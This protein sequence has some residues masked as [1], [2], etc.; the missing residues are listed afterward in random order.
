MPEPIK[1][2][3][4][5]NKKTGDEVDKPKKGDTTSKVIEKPFTLEDGTKLRE[6]IDII[7]YRLK[8]LTKIGDSVSNEIQKNG[9][10]GTFSYFQLGDPIEMESILEGD[11]LPGYLELARYIFYTATGEEFDPEKVD[12]KRNFI[13]E[14]KEYE[15]YL[16]YKPDIE[17][18]RTTAL[19]LDRAKN[20]GEYKN[21]KRLV[22]APSKY[23]DHDYLL[24]YRIDYCQLPFEIYKLKS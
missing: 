2:K 7:E 8:K 15:V 22:F 18:L 13:G 17:Y 4:Y 12:E 16:F 23:L 5:I 10:K 6:I 24:E 11:K 9:H 3:V 21:K 20:L 1:Q 19:T 14:S